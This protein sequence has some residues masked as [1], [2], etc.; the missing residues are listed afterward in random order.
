MT[1]DEGER[2]DPSVRARGSL[3]L[4]AVEERG[5]GRWQRN[6]NSCNLNP[7]PT[8]FSSAPDQFPTMVMETPTI[9]TTVFYGVF[10]ILNKLQDIGIGILVNRLAP[11]APTP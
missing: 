3:R 4:G 8:T 10:P 11:C 1:N 7:V 9:T 5:Q 6:C 2:F